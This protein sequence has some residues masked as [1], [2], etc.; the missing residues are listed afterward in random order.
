MG[1]EYFVFHD[2][3]FFWLLFIFGFHDNDTMSHIW[4]PPLTPFTLEFCPCWLAILSALSGLLLQ[5]DGS[6]HLRCSPSSSG[7]ATTISSYLMATVPY[8]SA[9]FSYTGAFK[10]AHTNKLYHEIILTSIYCEQP[11]LIPNLNLNSIQTWCSASLGP[12]FAP[13]KGYLTYRA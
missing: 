2:F 13:Y 7:V 11:E 12:D 9:F 6:L 5:P 1:K 10:H 4:W 3:H 8:R